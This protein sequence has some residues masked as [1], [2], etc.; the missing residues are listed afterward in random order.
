MAPV[1]AELFGGVCNSFGS[2]SHFVLIFSLPVL[3][4]IGE[5][6]GLDR[7]VVATVELYVMEALEWAPTAGWQAR[8]R[9]FRA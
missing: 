1:L 9:D 6:L 7:K 4:Q 5:L 2:R 8:R 3:Q